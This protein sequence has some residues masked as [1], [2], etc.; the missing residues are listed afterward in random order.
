[1][2]KISVRT[3]GVLKRTLGERFIIKLE[4]DSTIH[5]LISKL[6][7]RVRRTSRSDFSHNYVR[8]LGLT[9]LVN[10]QNIQALQKLETPLKD[11]DVV[12]FAP[13]VV[14]G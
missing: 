13:L 5:G 9:I 2:L 4:D 8:D 12:T 1:M 6:R 3:Y 14:G 11:G 7:T 10:G